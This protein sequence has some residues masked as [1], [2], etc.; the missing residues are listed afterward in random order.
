MSRNRWVQQIAA[1]LQPCMLKTPKTIKNC[2]SY[3]STAFPALGLACLFL[4]RDP[5]ICRHIYLPSKTNSGIA[6]VGCFAARCG[7]KSHDRNFGNNNASGK[8]ASG[9]ID[10]GRQTHTHRQIYIYI[11]KGTTWAQCAPR[12]LRGWPKLSPRGTRAPPA[13][14]ARRRHP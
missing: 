14:G 5:A 10:P 11:N 12:F 2:E 6:M 3:P 7:R 13:R 8:S 9:A 4:L 1:R